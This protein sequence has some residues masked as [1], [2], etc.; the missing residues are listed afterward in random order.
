MASS[1]IQAAKDANQQLQVFKQ[2]TQQ[3]QAQES[4][5]GE[6]KNEVAEHGR[7][8]ETL[9][10]VPQDRK[11]F[12]MIGGVLVERKVAEVIPAVEARREQISAAVEKINES[13]EETRKRAFA[14]QQALGV[15]QKEREEERQA[16]KP[17][18]G[19]LV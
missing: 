9:A 8:L 7:V 13:L 16:S 19:V 17:G 3:I 15:L 14:I 11:C 4:K 2:L 10:G 5:I 12:R 18:Q 6:L 1:D